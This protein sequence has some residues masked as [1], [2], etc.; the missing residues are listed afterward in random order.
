VRDVVKDLILEALLDDAGGRL[1]G[2]EAGD[3]R[4]ARVVARVALDLGVDHVTRDFDAYV[5]ARLVDVH[6]LGLHQRPEDKIDPFDTWRAL[7]E[8]DRL[9]HAVACQP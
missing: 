9:R 5:L 2:P 8:A 6:E 1:A 3:A 4:L 7:A